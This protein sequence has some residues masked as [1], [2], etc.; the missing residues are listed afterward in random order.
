[1]PLSSPA[2]AV[3]LRRLWAGEIVTSAELAA[4]ALR[5]AWQDIDLERQ[6]PKLVLV[7]A[8]GRRDAIDGA[9][10]DLLL[11]R[12]CEVSVGAITA[13]GWRSSSWFGPARRDRS[14]D[15]DVFGVHDPLLDT[16]PMILAEVRAAIPPGIGSEARAA[17]GA[18]RL[19]GASQHRLWFAAR[20]VAVRDALRS[21]PGARAALFK[22]VQ[23]YQR[24]ERPL[25]HVLVDPSYRAKGQL[26]VPSRPPA[27]S[28]S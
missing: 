5:D 10:G 22:A 16:Y 17:V 26:L 13:I 11:R 21:V 18:L 27:K 14:S 25:H 23:I 28:T 2:V 15:D 8:A 4:S 3:R 9:L 12:A 20:T 19:V 1:M 7:G 24:A 6:G